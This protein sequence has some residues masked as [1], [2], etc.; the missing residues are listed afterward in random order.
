MDTV[1]HEGHSAFD[2]LFTKSV[3]HIIEKIFFTLDYN[4][5]KICTG[6]EQHLE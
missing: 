2:T 1:K 3:P 6:G 5:F 4:S